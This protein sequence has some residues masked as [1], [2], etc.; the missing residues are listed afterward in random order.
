MNFIEYLIEARYAGDHPL[1]K[2]IKQA[3]FDRKSADVNVGEYN[4]EH[5][6]R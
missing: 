5:I 6:K 4:V 2:E 3:M 1:V